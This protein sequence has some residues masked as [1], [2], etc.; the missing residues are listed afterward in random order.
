ML[1]V[2]LVGDKE[3]I[4]KLNAMPNKVKAFLY[5]SVTK[6]AF[7]LEYKVKADKLSGQVL[8][9]RTGNLR[10]SIYNE[11]TQDTTSVTGRVAQAGDVKYGAIHEFGGQTPPHEIVPVKA[12]A[13]AFM[14]NGKQMFLKH[15]NHPGSKI[16]ERSYLRSSLSDMRDEITEGMTEAV[17]R[18]VA[19]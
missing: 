15:V 16:P 7:K 17:R 18:G 6:L 12:Q 1:N 4:A 19:I 8:H 13:L 14:W 2:S 9:V 3:L 5:A 10:A 11:V